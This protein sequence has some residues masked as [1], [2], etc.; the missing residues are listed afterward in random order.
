MIKT[1]FL[2]ITAEITIRIEA[3]VVICF[4]NM[5]TAMGLGKIPQPFNNIK[6]FSRFMYTRIYDLWESKKM[7]VKY[8]FE[9]HIYKSQK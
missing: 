1:D 8:Y 7:N 2:I 9:N 3:F 6:S 4:I 5:L